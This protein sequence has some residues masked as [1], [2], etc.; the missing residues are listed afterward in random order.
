MI[1][2]TLILVEGL[3]DTFEGAIIAPLGKVPIDCL[4]FGK[5]IG[6]GTPGNPSHQDIQQGIHHLSQ[7]NG[8]RSSSRL[9]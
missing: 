6:Q 7:V 2:C 1:S 3:I 5:V 9:Y 4:P 8:A